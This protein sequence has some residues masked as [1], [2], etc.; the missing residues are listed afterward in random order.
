MKRVRK[1]IQNEPIW[2]WNNAVPYE[3]QSLM[4]AMYRMKTYQE[5]GALL[6]TGGCQGSM[7]QRGTGLN[8]INV[9]LIMLL[10]KN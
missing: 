6:S 10:D 7:R 1:I 4:R 2:Q 9:L 3:M 8:P 5:L